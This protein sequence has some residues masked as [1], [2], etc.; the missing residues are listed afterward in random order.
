MNVKF[1][2]VFISFL[3]F[4]LC[5]FQDIRAQE[6]KETP[7]VPAKTDP[8]KPEPAKVAMAEEIEVVRP[9]KPVLANAAKIRRNPDLNDAPP[10]KP[11]LR[12]Q[13][14]D[15][16][17]EL[18]SDI[19]TLQYQQLNLPSTPVAVGN[20]LKA[21][22]G[23][24]KTG[25]GELYLNNG[26]DEALQT[27]LF[28]KY[29]SQEGNI[30]KQQFSQEQLGAFI[31][32]IRK[33]SSFNAQ[34]G[35][36]GFGT[37]FYGA[38]PLAL[39][40]DPNN[41]DRQ[42]LNLIQFATDLGSNYR[43][44]P[45]NF[46]YRFK[47]EANLFKNAA[48]SKENSFVIGG[49]F[50]K[51][52]KAFKLGLNS[53]ADL[54]AVKDGEYSLNNNFL[55]LNPSATYKLQDIRLNIGLNFVQEFGGVKRT[56]VFPNLLAEFSIDPEHAVV[57]AGVAGDVKKTSLTEFSFENPFLGSGI[58]IKNALESSHL[59]AGIKGNGGTALGYKAS[60]WIKQV[61]DL[62]LF[63]NTLSDFTRFEMVYVETSSRLTGIDLEVDIK[64]GDALSI[65]SKLQ[66]IKY[67]LDNEAKAW[68]R[69]A[70]RLETQLQ[71]SLSPKINLSGGFVYQGETFGR[72]A[73]A[74]TVSIKSFMNVN[75]A[76]SYRINKKWTGFVHANNLLN[77]EYQQFL[78]YP[79]LGLNIFGGIQYSF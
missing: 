14:L 47:L 18:N 21:G 6:T 67:D 8:A 66:A 45:E 35:Y 3:I 62:P 51:Q 7:A 55:R 58:I 41:P 65:Q 26:N 23:S 74:Q 4:G 11:V 25:I 9:Y 43:E 44:E 48:S 1:P 22:V 70:L 19:R 32:S 16:K 40:I 63:V 13:I 17:L 42:K 10:F 37:Y 56:K 73:S 36:S 39:P 77:Q 60:V 29:L 78:Y 24:M 15:K 28:A 12:Y 68:F 34:L 27:G 20:M 61:Q 57:F 64:A 5:S 72:D 54:T 31:K 46:T 49:M 30:N 53:T 76:A 52:W 38:N 2:I 50:N 71:A 79:Q 69:P 59:F 33:K 75:A